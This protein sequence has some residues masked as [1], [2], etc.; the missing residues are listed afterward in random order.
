MLSHK[1]NKK[2]TSNR[3]SFISNNIISWDIKERIDM[4]LPSDEAKFYIA[5]CS[6]KQLLHVK[7]ML[8]KCNV[9]QYAMTFFSNILKS[10][11]VEK[12]EN[13]V[14]ICEIQ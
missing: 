10:L 5:E 1:C 3:C 4:T 12:F 6:G 8:K 13:K 14:C 7:Q 11:D 2:S 9:R